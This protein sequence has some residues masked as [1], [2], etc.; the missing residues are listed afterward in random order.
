[1]NAGADPAK[2]AQLWSTLGNEWPFEAKAT[3]L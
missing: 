3:H 2:R 1:M